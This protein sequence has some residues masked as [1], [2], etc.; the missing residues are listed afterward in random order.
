MGMTDQTLVDTILSNMLH[1]S[2]P[3][4][5]AAGTGG[6]ALALT[7][8][9]HLHL[10][11]T[12]GT[13]SGTGTENVSGTSPGYTQG[14]PSGGLTMGS[15]AFGAF[16]SGAATNTNQVQWTASGTWTLG[17]AGIEVWDTSAT[18]IRILWG[19]LTTAIGASAVTNT[20]TITFAA[21]SIS[22]NASA[23]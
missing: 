22:A 3:G 5:W 20:D 14:Y 8:P 10:F 6:T 1:A 11:S 2:A 9:L 21:G 15:A 19:A 16:A 23:W 17:V 18:A 12:T 7:A 4:A 13:E